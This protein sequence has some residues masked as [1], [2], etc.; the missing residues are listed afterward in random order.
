MPTI[1]PPAPPS[2]PS[3]PTSK[4]ESCFALPVAKKRGIFVVLNAVEGWG[5]T[6]MGATAPG[7][8]IVMAGGETGYLTLL[9]RG[10]VPERPVFEADHWVALLDQ[11]DVLIRDPG[12]IRLLV[13][14][15]LSGLEHLCHSHVCATHYGG[16][17]GEK[18]F[19]GFK[20]GFDVSVSELV[21]MVSRLDQLKAANVNVLMLSH[22]FIRPFKNPLGPDFDRYVADVH[23]KTWGLIH[24]AADVVLFGNFFTVVDTDTKTAKKGKGVG[25]TVRVLYTER[26]DAFD[27]KNRLGLPETIDIPND[28]TKA[29]PTLQQHLFPNRKEA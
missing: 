26:R 5:K 10:L 7:S 6:T 8:A 12:D 18:G 25:G 2:V 13:L 16:D 28:A 20:R 17:W 4:T 15:A 9:D 11:L 27:A 21:K 1:A 24:K 19:T 22:S 23:Q 3:R 29:W 14:D